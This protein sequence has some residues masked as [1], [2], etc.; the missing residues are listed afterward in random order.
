MIEQAK[1]TYSALGKS[2]KKQTK[3]Q[4]D[5]LKYLNLSNK[6][7]DFKQIEGIFPQNQLNDLIIDKLQEIE[8]LQS[9]IKLDDPEYK[10]ERGKN[11]GF[12][13]YS[14]LVFLRDVC[15]GNL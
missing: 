13:K 2:L 7:D 4:V 8:Q 1:F 3:K 11:Y 12:T 10:T 6:K 9:N 14:L 15:E 5:V